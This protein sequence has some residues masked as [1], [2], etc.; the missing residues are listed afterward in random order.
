M[1]AGPAPGNNQFYNQILMKL[2]MNPKTQPLLQKP[3]FMAKM[4]MCMANPMM[5]MEMSK[6]D[7]DIRL[8]MEAMTEGFNPGAFNPGSFNPGS[9][10]AAFEEIPVPPK[11]QAYATPKP[12]PKAEPSK[13]FAPG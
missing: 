1:E 2:L 12:E 6:T 10:D 9:E 3:D 5:L 7:P 11:P 8:V 13:A 4:Q